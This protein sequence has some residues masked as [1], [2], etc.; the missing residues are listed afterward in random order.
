M[1]NTIE[2]KYR[3]FAKMLKF[4]SN[5]DLLVGDDSENIVKM[6]YDEDTLFS[7][8][9]ND[10]ENRICKCT[11]KEVRMSKKSH[12]LKFYNRI[13]CR[14]RQNLD[15]DPVYNEE[16]NRY[17]YCIAIDPDTEF[18]FNIVF[19]NKKIALSIVACIANIRNLDVY[20]NLRHLVCNENN[21]RIT[22]YKDIGS[23]KKSN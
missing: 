8:E 23:G 4:E 11:L 3:E 19:N 16:V 5:I 21:I 7:F 22:E 17:K 12:M 10:K 2:S 6:T 14:I 1:K 9:F 18:G 20:N 13:I 15:F